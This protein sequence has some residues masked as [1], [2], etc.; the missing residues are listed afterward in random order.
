MTTDGELEERAAMDSRRFY[1]T[2]PF[3]KLNRLLSVANQCMS[4]FRREIE[5]IEDI[6]LTL[7]IGFMSEGPCIS[8]CLDGITLSIFGQPYDVIKRRI[9]E[10]LT[11]R[12]KYPWSET[13]FSVRVKQGYYS[14]YL[15]M[16]IRPE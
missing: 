9:E 15:E 5:H 3:P 13:A 12:E 2:D 8:R 4:F 6:I 11:E 16:S 7:D 10:F 1:L 14:N